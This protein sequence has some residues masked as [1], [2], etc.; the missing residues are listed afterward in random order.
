MK[1]FLLIAGIIFGII[2]VFVGLLELRIWLNTPQVILARLKRGS[3][4]ATQL[5]MKLNLSRGDTTPLIIEAYQDSSADFSFRADML[6]I[7][8]KKLAP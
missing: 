4:N 8:F 2:A 7:L 1:R 5:K 3:G 6:D